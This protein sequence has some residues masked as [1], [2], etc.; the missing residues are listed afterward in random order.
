MS[1][2]TYCRTAGTRIHQ[3]A[4]FLPS[5]FAPPAYTPV[6]VKAAQFHASS[7][8]VNILPGGNQSGK[9]T[10]A[11]HDHVS[12]GR[13][14]PPGCQGLALTNTYKDIGKQLWKHYR[15]QLHP[16]E[17]TVAW[18]NR[19]LEIPQMMKL[20]ANGYKI[21]FGSYDQGRSAH[22][23]AIWDYVHFDEEA[24]Y[25]IWLEVYR[26]TLAHKARIGYS[27]TPIEGY[28]YLEEL[29]DKGHDPTEFAYWTPDKPM[30]LFEN[31][32]IS[33]EEIDMWMAM[34]GERALRVRIYGE[35]MGAEGLVYPDYSDA[36]HLCDPFPIPSD[37]KMYR[38]ID[39]G[40][41]H[42]T[43]SLILA[44][45][46]WRMYVIDEYYQANRLVEYHIEQMWEQWGRI[47]LK[48]TTLRPRLITISDHDAQLRLEYANPRFGDK[49]IH[50]IPAI[51]HH[52]TKQTSSGII[53][54]IEVVES[55]LKIQSDGKPRL[56]IFP[57][58]VETRKE[59]KKYKRP[60]RDKRGMLKPG[61]K[62]ETPVPEHDHC[63]DCI[64]Y[65]CVQ[66]FGYLNQQI[67]QIISVRK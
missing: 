7:A 31:P 66:E 61:E 50:S 17:Y 63:M 64:R 46:G 52:P 13:A 18:Q 33:Q 39:F 27:Y 60:D 29:I 16:Q 49:R 1:L 25:D 24:P 36:T 62:A 41:V 2:A 59:F 67:Y 15:E 53:A 45:D 23:G 40:K 56:M 5:T 58:C 8:K 30:S 48:D 57:Q 42:P 10:T 47:K 51:K 55:L 6:N 12:K 19:A 11:A 34:L 22:Q 3:T 65:G 37:W 43:V 38:V 54:G 35:M 20:N 4:C 21:F 32:H 14:M 26:G 44:T 28:D 9:T